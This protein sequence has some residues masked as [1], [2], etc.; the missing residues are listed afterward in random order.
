VG[1][2]GH[3]RFD[4]EI[5][6]GTHQGAHGAVQSMPVVTAELGVGALEGRV[7]VSL[8]LLDTTI[9]HVSVPSSSV[10]CQGVRVQQVQSVSNR[11]RSR[12]GVCVP[13]PVVLL[14]LV[15]LRRVL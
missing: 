4:V 13:V 14:R 11:V 2:A 15:V 7:T 10:I 3:V 9:H 5:V 8:R 6:G 1:L 12:R